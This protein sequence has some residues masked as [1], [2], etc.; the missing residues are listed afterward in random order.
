MK[1]PT[2]EVATGRWHQIL[3]EFGI[4]SRYLRNKH[5]PC[6]VCE[7]TDR[8]RWDNKAGTGSFFCTQCGPGD[9]FKLLENLTGQA[10][11]QIAARVDEICHNAEIQPEQPKPRKDPA[12]MLRRI[13]SE[14]QKISVGDPV[15][16]YLRNRGIGA[17]NFGHMRIHPGL[18]YYDAGQKLG[19]FPAMVGAIRNSQGKLESLHITYVTPEGEKAPVPA[20]KKVMSPR[21]TIT[22]SAIRLTATHEI[23]A[24]TEGI[25]NALAVMENEGLPCWAAVSAHGIETFQPPEGVT[26]VVV[27]GDNDESF[28][29]QAAAALLCKRLVKE[30]L[31]A[32]C[33]IK[34]ER[35]QD[36]LDYYNAKR[37]KVAA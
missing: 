17:S 34:G 14:L 10:F 9:G 5:G 28:T 18:N 12:P 26:G 30:G 15:Y 20:V 24:I 37:E 11:A 23:I 22:G 8:F 13:A 33:I 36:Y 29:G 1:R 21:N 7:G 31:T 4:E 25:E 16:R 2:R 6:P 19:T 3:P 27:Y 32:D 35:G